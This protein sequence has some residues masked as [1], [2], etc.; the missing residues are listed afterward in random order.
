MYLV[1]RVISIMTL[2][3]CVNDSNQDAAE[4][5]VTPA[6][7]KQGVNRVLFECVEVSGGRGRQLVF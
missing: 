4:M 7:P 5:E 6:E 2:T 3:D 1:A